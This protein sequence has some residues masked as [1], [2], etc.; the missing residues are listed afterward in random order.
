MDPIRVGMSA[1]AATQAVAELFESAGDYAVILLDRQLRIA[2]WNA[3]ASNLFGYTADEVSG[4]RTDLLFTPEDR[5]Q[6]VPEH[7]AEMARASPRA[8]NDRWHIR[9]DGSRFWASGVLIE[10]ENGRGETAGF[11]KI[12]RDRT[13]LR[14]QIE[15][16]KNRLAATIE[17]QERK[18][19]M[20][21]TLAHELRNPLAP[22]T[23]AAQLIRLAGCDDARLAYPLQIIERQ[24]SFF[25]RLIDDLLDVT[26][27][28]AG[29]LRLE[30]KRFVLQ[31][32]LNDALD[33][34]RPDAAARRQTLQGV[35][36]QAPIEVEADR[37]RVVQ[38][39][40]NLLGNAVRY[41]PSEGCVWLKATVE[42]AH[43]V[44][45]VE[46]TGQGIP[47]ELQP[48]IFDLF[49]QGT[50]S[51]GRA[52]GL[53]IGLA[54]VKELVAAHGGTVAVRSEGVGRG[55]EFTV[56]LPLAPLRAVGT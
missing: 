52:G 30:L 2:F 26:R 3:G 1:A 45:R 33:T 35:L 15:T 8:H 12:M 46:D 5:Q 39:V 55:S 42:A 31:D 10:L 25:Q 23:N 27:V 50:P 19:V 38:I 48:R 54:L 34:A 4:Q 18:T 51:A 53:G 44:L 41:T 16:L 7:E 21:G 28:S 36:P 29:K 11:A 24:I 9:K 37:D 20:L 17:Q 6:R 47:L 13:D 56:R 22:L 40:V 49:T 14:M 32:A 43:A